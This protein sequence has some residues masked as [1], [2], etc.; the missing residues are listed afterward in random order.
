[1]TD[2]APSNEDDGVDETRMHRDR[3][4]RTRRM[5]REH[6]LPAALLFDPLNIRY[7]LT[8]GPFM[9]FNMHSTFRWA[10]VP[11]ESEPVL[12]EYPHAMHITASEW[13]GDLRPA[14]GW[15]FLGSGSN[16]AEDAAAFASEIVAELAKRDLLTERIGTDRLE[17]AG[18]L[19]LSEAGVRIVDAQPALERA[20][21]VKTRDE[22]TAIRANV[23]ACDQAIGDMLRILR[24]GVTENELWGT[25]VGNALATGSEW[26]ETRLLSSGPRTNPW[27]QSA[28]ARA[29]RDGELVAFDTDLVGEHGYLTDVSRTYLCGDHRASDEQRR[30]YQTAYEFLQTCIPEFRPGVSFEDLGHRLGPLFPPEFQP[31]RYPYI[32]HGT[33]LVDEYPVVNFT[34]HHEGELEAG[35]VL[36]VESYVGSVGGHEGVKLEE[37]LVV[38]HDGPELLSTAPFDQRLLA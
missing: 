21:A 36:S 38:G 15:T 24:P 4:A 34:R 2:V 27:M 33:G 10:L 8:P 28:T 3:L 14:H 25:I 6:Q 5:L 12:W 17:S 20:R 19:A 22:L 29:V 9:V 30:L 1:M 13:D 11:A 37:Q 16:S 23:A 7:A 18:H 32:A 35:M 31:Q 26:C